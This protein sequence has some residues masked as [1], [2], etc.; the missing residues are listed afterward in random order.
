MLKFLLTFIFKRNFDSAI[1]FLMI[2]TRKFSEKDFDY[3]IN[4]GISLKSNE[5]FESSLNV[6]KSKEINPNSPLH[7]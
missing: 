1:S 5:E 2:T 7:S 4:M 3:Y 6:Q